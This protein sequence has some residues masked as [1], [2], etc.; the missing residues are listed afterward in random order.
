M[1]RFFLLLILITLISGCATTTPNITHTSTLRPDTGFKLLE[2]IQHL[3]EDLA[4]CLSSVKECPES[5][6]ICNQEYEDSLKTDNPHPFHGYHEGYCK[7][8]EVACL[9][10]EVKLN[11]AIVE[12]CR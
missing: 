3:Q 9:Q 7:T 1:K 8:M 6:R 4:V 12:L 11:E 2:E 5:V 10:T